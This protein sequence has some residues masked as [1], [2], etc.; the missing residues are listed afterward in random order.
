MLPE[1]ASVGLLEMQ[2]VDAVAPPVSNSE[3]G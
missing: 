3:V 2:L 1:V